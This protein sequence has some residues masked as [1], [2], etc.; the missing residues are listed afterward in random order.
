MLCALPWREPAAVWAALADRGWPILLESLT[1]E[2]SWRHDHA[3][4]S[5][6]TAEPFSTLTSRG[7]QVWRDGVV[8]G[9]DP[10]T[11]LAA[12]LKAL[13]TLDLPPSLPPFV[14][15]AA[16]YWG[17]EL[18]PWLERLPGPRPD[19]FGP[20]DICLGLYD[21][22]IAFDHLTQRCRLISTGLPEPIP[23]LRAT[24]ARERGQAWLAALDDMPAPISPRGAT[25]ADS[26]AALP[27]F[28][29]IE[30]ALTP[31]AYRAAVAR[32]LAYLHAG[33]IYQANLAQRFR[34]EAEQAPAPLALYQRLRSYNPAPFSALME[35][36]HSGAI[37][38]SS[39]ERFLK[40]AGDRV[41][42]RPIKGTRRRSPDPAED[43][44]LAA[45][46]MASAK[47]QAENLMIV[48]LLRNDLSRVCRPGSVR[49]P[50]LAALESHATVHHLVS[51]VTG[52]LEPGAGA[53][54]LLRACF[55][56]GS[57]T[58]APKLRAMEIIHELEPVP[59]GP[60][61]GCFGYLGVDGALDTA[62]AIRTLVVRDRSVTCHA[63]GAIV[64]DSDPEEE[65][66]EIAAK[67]AALLRVVDP[68]HRH[69]TT[70]S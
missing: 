11:A 25:P 63:G 13:P 3:R 47:D 5:F 2:P 33:D 60:Y 69:R 62:I 14:G 20:P 22:V 65:A 29:A 66:A 21:R 30:T 58:G 18:G 56:G 37:V 7:G 15:G 50:A 43:A 34:V 61:C 19:P 17:Y 46:L 1:P 38:A 67:V 8:V 45:A 27:R 64:L 52:R 68:Y 16:G 23:S 39:P 28:G 10:F 49:V 70:A 40:V 6:V 24:R 44:A 4:Y 54:D 51:T 59:R 9:G 57:V 36:G 32:I 41:E 55:P 31:T 26:L 35:F 48:D 12:M 53:L 42:T